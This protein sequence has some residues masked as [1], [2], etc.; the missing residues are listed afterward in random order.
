MNYPRGSQI[1][2]L[3]LFFSLSTMFVVNQIVP[4]GSAEISEI[5]EI[6]LVNEYVG[7]IAAVAINHGGT[8]FGL[9]H[10]PPQI[11]LE[12]ALPEVELSQ[13][14]MQSFLYRI[15]KL[16][17]MGKI[18]QQ[19][20][21]MDY[22]LDPP[23]SVCTV[24]L[25]N[26]EKIRLALGN[27]NPVGDSSYL[28]K[29]GSEEIYLLSS[30]DSALLTVAPKDFRNRR[31]L[32]QIEMNDLN[33]IRRISFD[34]ESPDYKDFIIASNDNFEFR[35]LE[36]FESSLDYET[37][38]SKIIFPLISLN[39]TR[40]AET[41]EMPSG[42]G[43]RISVLFGEETYSLLF[44]KA[45]ESWFI[46]REDIQRVFEIDNDEVPWDNLRYRELLNESVYHVNISQIDR[47]EIRDL[48]T[49]YTLEI[50]GRSTDMSGNL[51]GKQ[52]EYPE[53]M[54]FYTTLFTTGIAEI[55]EGTEREETITRREPEVTI[56]V[57]KKTG[58]IDTLEFFALGEEE[59]L[60]A[61][62]GKV[63][64]AIYNTFL[65]TLMEMVS[66]TAS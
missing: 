66:S 3:F 35:L 65:Q 11:L 1:S 50:T 8:R 26:G 49:P 13:E 31:V 37:V 28:I 15:S 63:N 16:K 21:L 9:I 6:Q 58:A 41:S 18:D 27:I 19:S 29:E 39:P 22:G 52:L 25:R 46:M 40:I 51:N 5:E 2:A 14:E 24:I 42:T 23:R 55:I 12:P 48:S 54:E 62:N 44:R 34:H 17:A 7:D 53:V 32:P 4:E 20:E 33:R 60:V 36:P 47:I 59:S 38:L 45:E 57:Y 56:N 30:S 61:I 43:F 10:Q 64:F